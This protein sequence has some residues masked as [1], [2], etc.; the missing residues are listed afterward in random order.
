MYAQMD[1]ISSHK[2][3]VI[4]VT[5][6]AKHAKEETLTMTAY[7]VNQAYLSILSAQNACQARRVILATL[8]IDYFINALK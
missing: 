1:T 2:L 8:V 4:G 5:K 6:H 7:F 3:F